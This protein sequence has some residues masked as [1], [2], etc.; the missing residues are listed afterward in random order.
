[1]NSGIDFSV[2][3]SVKESL[4]LFVSVYI[5]CLYSKQLWKN[6]THVLKIVPSFYILSPEPSFK[7]NIWYIIF[8][9]TYFCSSRKLVITLVHHNRGSHCTLLDESSPPSQQ[10]LLSYLGCSVF[11]VSSTGLLVFLRLTSATSS[12]SSSKSCQAKVNWLAA[13]FSHLFNFIW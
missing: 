12:L 11:Q 8:C 5:L 9:A 4:R 6:Y 13:S 10:Q 7:I 3:I 2:C 1:M